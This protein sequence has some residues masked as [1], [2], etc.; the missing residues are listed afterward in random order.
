MVNKDDGIAISFRDVT[1]N[2]TKMIR[3]ALEQYFLKI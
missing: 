1:K 3:N 2:Y